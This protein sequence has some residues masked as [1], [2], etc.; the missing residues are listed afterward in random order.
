MVTGAST[1]DL[2]VILVDASKG[3]LR[4]TR[5]HSTLVHFL[6]IRNLVLA[7]NKMDLVDYGEERFLDI[8]ADYRAFARD[9]GIEEFTAIPL[10]GFTGENVTSRSDQM[11]WYDGPSLLE[12]LH[13]VQVGA[14]AV[15]GDPFRMAVQW[16]NRPNQNFRG[17]A[18]TVASGRI[19]AGDSIEVLPA[20]RRATID[21]IVTYDGDLA[22]A[23]AGQAVT[24]TFAEEID[25][26]RGDIIV[27]ANDAAQVGTK[28]VATL[29]GMADQ[30]LIT[31]RAYWLKIGT[32][33]VSA[34][35]RSVR[36]VIDID[37]MQNRPADAIGFNEIAEVEIE[38]ARSA[39]AVPYQ[40][41]RRLGGFILIDKLSHATVAAGLTIDLTQPSGGRPV[42]SN[43]PGIVWVA[44]KG[45]DG[46][47]AEAARRLRSLGQNAIIIDEKAL[48]DFRAG[49]DVGDAEPIRIARELAA[50]LERAGVHVLLTIPATEGEAYPGRRIIASGQ[51]E[52]GAGEWVI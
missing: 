14:R 29:V 51:D 2:A 8:V 32:Q 27:T 24:L 35:I 22:E 13:A 18:G 1:A 20:G 46:H 42:E 52:E 10:S 40:R 6:G 44:G 12:H 4:Q 41:N 5:R 3:V 33:T 31:R 43:H 17:Y 23:R 47:A 28:L 49:A 26:S 39:T 15:R 19:R 21:R 45:A 25:C 37:T 50:L 7:V 30:P 11:P 38:L 36:H 9:A 34:T 16:V 48:R